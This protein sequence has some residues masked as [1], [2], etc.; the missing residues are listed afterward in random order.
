MPLFQSLLQA[1]E[2]K[3]LLE[4]E[5]YFR[6]VRAV[7]AKL[8]RGLAGA[9][10]TTTGPK[11]TAAATAGPAVTAAATAGPAVTAAATAGP[12]ATAA[13]D[14][15]RLCSVIEFTDTHSLMVQR[16]VKK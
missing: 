14:T 2:Q 3:N 6:L 12:E 4:D 8:N 13:A 15:T 1:T 16:Y 10:T 11:A 9:A 5:L 7:T